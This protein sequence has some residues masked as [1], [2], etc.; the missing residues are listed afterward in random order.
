MRGPLP[1]SDLRFSFYRLNI[2]CATLTTALSIRNGNITRRHHRSRSLSIVI[3]IRC[4][5]I[6]MI[7]VS[8]C[9][10]AR[11]SSMPGG[12]RGGNLRLPRSPVRRLL[13]FYLY[14]L[15]CLLCRALNWW[16]L[17]ILVCRIGRIVVLPRIRVVVRVVEDYVWRE[18]LDD[19]LMLQ[20]LIRRESLL[21]I[22]L[23]AAADEIH[24]GWIRHFSQFVHNVA[25]P[26]LFLIISQHL[27]R[28]WHCIIFEL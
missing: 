3:N 11:V 13:S 28:R 4:N 6:A 9:L 25:E 22:P 10:S 21:R 7:I 12:V 27:E 2:T 18:A 26:L 19:P 15:A 16:W 17:E 1:S 24:E 5:L 20:P 8:R 23:Q 14:L